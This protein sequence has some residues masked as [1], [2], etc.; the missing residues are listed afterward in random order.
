MTEATFEL[1]EVGEPRANAD[2]KVRAGL[3]SLKETV[4]G[5]LDNENI[6]AEAGI[7][8]T[9]LAE[10]T[11]A[12][13]RLAKVPAACVWRGSTQELTDSTETAISFSQAVYDND[14]MWELSSPTKLT[15]KTAGLYYVAFTLTSFTTTIEDGYAVVMKNGGAFTAALNGFV[16]KT[17]GSGLE[18]LCNGSTVENLAANDYLELKASINVSSGKSVIYSFDGHTPLLRVA[19]LGYE[20]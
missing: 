18:W 19:R 2:P 15:I 8:G 7:V 6:K 14:S 9:K 1:P 13:S 17:P 16:K 11:V 12:P 10:K 20:S 5:K 4:N 3:S